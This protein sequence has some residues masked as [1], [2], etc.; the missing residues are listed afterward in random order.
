MRRW[1]AVR[2]RWRVCRDVVLKIV[3]WQYRMQGEE[4]ECTAG[5]EEEEPTTGLLYK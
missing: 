2:R 3:G 1:A 5:E 4:S